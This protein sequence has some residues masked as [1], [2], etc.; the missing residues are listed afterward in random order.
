MIPV[1]I[2][3]IR[4]LDDALLSLGEGA[5]ALGFIFHRPSPR[6]I[7]PVDAA[8]LLSKI[9]ERSG[10][11]FRA[12]GVFVDWDLDELNAV[13]REVG[14]DAAQLHGAEAPGYAASV[15]AAEVW[16]AFRVG[17][18]FE[19]SRPD[20]YPSKMRVLL[21]GWSPTEA[22]G[23]GEV[24]DWSIARACQESRPVFLAGGIDAGNIAAAIAEV[25]PFGIDVSSGVESSPGIKDGELVR[26]LFSEARACSSD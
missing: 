7:E 18:D 5:W 17:P 23:T 9:R 21:D 1:K 22:G 14:L 6:F 24:F 19:A 20:D 2:C 16:K 26:R 3:G 8:A 25:R 10:A 12:V 15:E 4:R 13:V 11:E